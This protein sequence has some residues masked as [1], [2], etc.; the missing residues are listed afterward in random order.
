MQLS[1]GP[2]VVQYTQ[3][4]SAEDI[5]QGDPLGPMLFCLGIHKL[6]SALSSEFNVFYFDDGTIGR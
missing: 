3:I 6:V 5:Q 4:L 1:I 2:N